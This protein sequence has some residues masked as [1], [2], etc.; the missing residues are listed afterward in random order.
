[1]MT[2]EKLREV[3]ERLRGMVEARRG[4]NTWFS[5]NIFAGHIEHLHDMPDK[6]LGF[7]AEGR[8][9]KLMRWV[10]FMQGALWMMGVDLEE[11]KRM[12]MPDEE[13]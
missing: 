2:E 3:I 6:M 13:K 11:L 10:G 5:A 12:N 4:I 1:M 8:R 7:L 9:E